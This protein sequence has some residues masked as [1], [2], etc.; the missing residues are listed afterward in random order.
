MTTAKEAPRIEVTQGRRASRRRVRLRARAVAHIIE[1]IADGIVVTD[2]EGSFLVFNAAAQRILGAGPSAGPPGTWTE[3]YGLYLPDRVTPYPPE[4][5]PLARALR[6]EELHGVEILVRNPANRQDKVISVSALPWRDDSGA[7]LG[8]VAVFRDVTA[9]RQASETVQRLSNAV[10][11]TADAIYITDRDGVIQYVNPGFEHITGWSRDEAV[12]RTP[13][14]LRSG[15]HDGEVYRELWSTLLAGE[16]FRATMVNRRK[17]GE[18]FHAE[19]TIT[20]IQDEAGRVT[21][22]VA[23][24]KD[25]TE[26]RLRQE[27]EVELSLARSVQRALFPTRAPRTPGLDIAGLAEPATE[28]CGDYFDSI[29]LPGERLGLVIGDVSGHGLGPAI[30]MAGARAYLRAYLRA[31]PGLDGALQALNETLLA[32]LEEGRFV[33]MLLA[34]IDPRTLRMSYANAGHPP[35]FVVD[36]AGRV[37]A[38]LDSSGTPLGAFPDCGARALGPVALD[39][40]DTV[41]LLTD[42]IVESRAPDG[43]LLGSEGALDIVR[44][45]LGGSAQEILDGLVAGVREHTGRARQEDDVTAIVCRVVGDA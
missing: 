7:Q 28:M 11:H 27:R 43:C 14:I 32:D 15:L 38:A 21:H 8:A 16:V 1:T 24:G 34:V 31:L 13:R 37:R 35:G 23:V 39:R 33:T 5:L 22:F 44:R 29:T 41:V 45:H 2:C 20:P 42:G 36:A 18:I 25:M 12:G 9:H 40:G 17:S 4:R 26:S 30:V 10:E 3:A 6:G 19:M